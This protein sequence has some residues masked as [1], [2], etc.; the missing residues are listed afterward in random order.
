MVYFYATSMIWIPNLS[1]IRIKS[2]FLFFP[3]FQCLVGI[4]ILSNNPTSRDYTN[5]FAT[6]KWKIIFW[7]LKNLSRNVSRV[8]NLRFLT[9]FV[10]THTCYVWTILK[11]C[12]FYAVHVTALGPPSHPLGLNDKS[13]YWCSQFCISCNTNIPIILP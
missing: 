12:H 6:K 4:E 1:D 10:F 9:F 11:I 3:Q 13:I 2:V 8:P 7:S 5:L